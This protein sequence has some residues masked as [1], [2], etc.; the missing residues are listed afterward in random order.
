MEI[1]WVGRSTAFQ[2]IEIWCA[3]KKT[4]VNNVNNVSEPSSQIP[5]SWRLVPLLCWQKRLSIEGWIAT[6]GDKHVLKFG[7]IHYAISRNTLCKLK[8]Y[9]LKFEEKT[10]C[11]FDQY[12]CRLSIEDGLRQLGTSEHWVWI[13][14]QPICIEIQCWDF[15]LILMAEIFI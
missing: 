14:T 2:P 3:D 9:I 7:E 1:S 11:Y 15:F 6:T 13:K 10:F 5:D 8:K 4:F 12:I